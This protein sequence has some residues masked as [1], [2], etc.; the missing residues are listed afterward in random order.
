M[1]DNLYP[2][3]AL[4]RLQNARFYLTRGAAVQLHDSVERYYRQ[5]E[6][7]F[8]KT[9]RAVF[10]LCQKIDKNA[11]NLE[12]K[13]LEND[14]YC[15]LIPNL[16][17]KAVRDVI[18]STKNKIEKGRIKENDQHFFIPVRTMTI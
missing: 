16:S 10:D 14:E 1:K 2:P 5:G 11:H 6:W 18:E 7:S 9:E 4:Q 8:D 17:L 3:T 13:D 12:L 15:S